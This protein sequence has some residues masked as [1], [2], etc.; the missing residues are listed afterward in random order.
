Y[1][2]NNSARDL[3]KARSEGIG[4]IVRGVGNPFFTE[5]IH[6]IERA[7]DAAGYSTSLHQIGT[8]DDELLSGAALAR[9]KKLKGL[10]FLGGKGD[11][12]S[13]DIAILDVPFVCCTYTVRFT[14]L[15]RESYSSDA[16]DDKMEGYRA[17]RMLL[18]KGHR[19]IGVLLNSKHDHSIGELRYMGYCEA[20]AGAG[21]T[22]EESL[23]EETGSFSLSDAYEATGRLVRRRPDLTA[24]F[25]ISDTM[26]MA[27]IKALHDLGRAVPEDCSVISIDGMDMTNYILPPLATMAQPQEELGVTAVQ[28]L[29]DM[30]E[31][32]AG[33]RHIL[34]PATPRMG[35]SVAAI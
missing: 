1:V 19:K 13:S 28:T 17:V 10:I 29:V 32:R 26:G 27:A 25:T 16:I 2:P 4:L 24:I 20:L 23:V 14:Q 7:I 18:D 3:L 6:A 12:Q 35:G 11:Y 5:V 8:D 31:G 9:A 30:I 21:S 34:L 22:V 33:N 15:P